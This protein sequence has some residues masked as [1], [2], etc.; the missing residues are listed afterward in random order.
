MLEILTYL[1][2]NC[3]FFQWS[4]VQGHHTHHVPPLFA[5]PLSLRL[6]RLFLCNA[7][8]LYFMIRQPFLFACVV[9]SS[10][11]SLIVFYM[12]PEMLCLYRL[13]CESLFS[14]SAFQ[15]YSHC[16][17]III[18]VLVPVSQIDFLLDV[19]GFLWEGWVVTPSDNPTC[20][21]LTID[22]LI[23]KILNIE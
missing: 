7:V 22:R 3:T 9:H 18:F 13:P 14:G 15:T 19:L 20:D 2:H 16:I 12:P 6:F 8:L 11:S 10:T 21:I 5:I 23:I 4:P 17:C 1:H